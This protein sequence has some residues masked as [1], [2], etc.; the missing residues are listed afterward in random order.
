MEARPAVLPAIGQPLRTKVL[1]R[2]AAY[3]GTSFGALSISGIPAIKAPFEPLVPGAIK[4]QNTNRY[5]C[6]DCSHLDACTLRC[7][8]DI[9]HADRDGGTRDRRRRLLEPVQNTGG[10]LAPPPGYFERVREICD[11][12][13]V[14]LVSDEVIAAFG[15][16]GHWFGS[17]RYD[18]QPDIITFAKGVTSGY[19]PMGGMIVS[20]RLA[21][22]FLHGDDLFLHGITFGGHPVSLRCRAREHRH[23]RT[24]GPERH[25]LSHEDDFGAHRDGLRDLPIV[26]DVRGDGVLPCHRARARSRR[27]LSVPLH[28]PTVR[29]RCIRKMGVSPRACSSPGLICH[30]DDRVDPVIVQFAPLLTC[31]PDEFAEIESTLH[32]VL[33][34]AQKALRVVTVPPC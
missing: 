12:Y 22:P 18:Y 16:L 15:R 14:L 28:A 33:T 29:R 21:A 17:Q 20:D 7:A 34:E 13:G 3:H 30:A 11:R 25:V 24:G 5:R 4:V 2:Y 10:A 8:D 1:S 23:P 31:G 9:A 32:A 27:N 19:S 26:G 6:P